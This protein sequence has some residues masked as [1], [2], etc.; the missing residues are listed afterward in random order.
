MKKVCI[1][2]IAVFLMVSKGLFAA[3]GRQDAI[4]PTTVTWG[5]TFLIGDGTLD[6]DVYRYLQEQ[7]NVKI[8]YTFYDSDRMSLILASGD[9]PDIVSGTERYLPNVFNNKLAMNL[10]PI[11]ETHIPNALS[12]IFKLRDDLVRM[13]LGGS[14]NGLYII[15]CGLGPEGGGGNADLSRCYSVRW[16]YYKAIGAPP[17]NNDDDFV[18]A[19]KAMAERFPT[20]PDGRKTLGIGMVN[21]FTSFFAHGMVTSGLNIWTFRY[22]QYMGDFVTNEIHNGYTDTSRSA[23]WND[24]KLWNKLYREGLFDID[25]FTMT[26]DEFNAK[27][28]SGLYVASYSRNDNMYNEMRKTDPNTLAGFM[29]IP[30][31]GAVVFVDNPLIFGNAPALYNFISSKSK[32]WEAAARII[33]VMHDP[34]F[35]RIQYSG[36]KGVHW[37]Y[38]AQG[39]PILFDST[40]DA[41]SENSEAWKKT[42]IRNTIGHT[43]TIDS[44]AMHPDGYLFGLFNEKAYQ[45]N[46]RGLSPLYLDYSNFYNVLYPSAALNNLVQEG[47]TKGLGNNFVEIISV[48]LNDVP[49]DIERTISNLDNILYRA[50][51]RLITAENDAVFNNEVQRT[52]NDLRTAGEPQA[53]E[54]IRTNYNK[55][56]IMVDPIISEYNALKKM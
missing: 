4:G 7:A 19:I 36:F 3:G 47:K 1:I 35:I 20:I 17:I 44:T 24:M 42:G 29:P 27:H 45:S 16:D 46:Q 51:P 11:L 25:S 21:N 13:F 50:L 40:I 34:D 43:N 28:N 5:G 32:N 54:W 31:T 14:D 48:G 53:W 22:S 12:P 18:S 39:I 33:N 15:S 37:D 9:L 52:L 30:S 38:N 2:T 6:T 49:I 26:T 8:D 41:Y 55:Y 10:D 56:K 23:Y